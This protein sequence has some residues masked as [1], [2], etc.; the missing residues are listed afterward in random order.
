MVE[1][2]VRTSFVG[3]SQK[4]FKKLVNRIDKKKQVLQQW[5]EYK[6]RHR[7]R[8]VD[9]VL[10]LQR[11]IRLARR[12]M[13]LFIHDILRPGGKK[14]TGLRLG[15][16][17]HNKLIHVLLNLTNGLLGTE[18]APQDQE[19]ENIHNE[20]SSLS[21]KEAQTLERDQERANYEKLFGLDLSDYDGVGDLLQFA[22]DKIQQQQNAEEE[23]RAARHQKKKVD[24]SAKL[25]HEERA[26]LSRKKQ[27]AHAASLSVKEVYRKLVSSLHPDREKDP[28]ERVRKTEMMQK[29]NHAYAGNDLL[30]LL[31]LQL[32]IEQI[33]SKHI[34]ML[35]EDRLNNFIRVLRSQ[36]EE[37]EQEI[38]S[39]RYVFMGT[40]SFH[41]TL[42]PKRVDLDLDGE[43]AQLRG[44]ASQLQTDLKEFN[45]PVILRAWLKDLPAQ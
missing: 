19:L 14:P 34:L 2:V 40:R 10:P 23:K 44:V 43:V 24:P 4:V 1:E 41:G 28:L 16:V 5:Q 33:D 12:E 22:L 30:T 18:N 32:E 31:N 6:A 29:V 39:E 20:Y 45:D 35:S 38:Q 7:Q 26:L 27:E 37:L 9:E 3:K 8:M 21:W 15:K 11:E 13:V 36:L 17:Q 25:N 42:T